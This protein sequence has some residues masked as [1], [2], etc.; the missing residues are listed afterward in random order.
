MV[1][2]GLPVSAATVE[3]YMG[4]N[5]L[6]V[7]AEDVLNT[8]KLNLFLASLSVQFEKT[9]DFVD[10]YTQDVDKY[11]AYME[12][13]PSAWPIIGSVASEFGLRRDPIHGGAANHTGIDIK[14]STGA[15]V[16]ATGAGTVTRSD[17][18]GGY[19]YTVVIN[20]GYGI[21][22]LYAHNSQLLAK[23]GDKVK[24]GDIIA[25]AGSTG[26]STG[27]H[28]HYEVIVNGT[29]RNPRNYLSR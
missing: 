21:E 13:I 8:D 19:G 10:K 12:A 27:P 2:D 6:P 4:G 22:T 3:S 17:Y 11:V 20:H 26:R 28:V 1:L 18:F 29:P 23:R 7:F 24:R 15:P 25:R 14:A 9:E 16:R 5:Y